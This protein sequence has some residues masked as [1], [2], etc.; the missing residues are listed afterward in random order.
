MNN[1]NDNSQACN[2]YA[3]TDSNVQSFSDG[4]QIDVFDRCIDLIHSK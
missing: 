4:L 1:N 2:P 3:A